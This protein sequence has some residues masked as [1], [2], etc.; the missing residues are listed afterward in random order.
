MGWFVGNCDSLDKFFNA[1][2]GWNP[3]NGEG[4]VRKAAFSNW[5]TNGV[6]RLCG[7]RN[8]S[9]EMLK[10]AGLDIA[11]ITV[12]DYSGQGSRT[13]EQASGVISEAQAKRLWAI[14][15][16][17]GWEQVHV[18]ILLESFEIAHTADILR[19]KYEGIIKVLEQAPPAEIV[20]EAKNRADGKKE[21][22]T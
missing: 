4:D 5:I 21:A 6:T 20:A 12:V 16:G 7:I 11:K 1:R 9:E 15:R 22:S 17:K 8:P 10:K 18:S 3:S 2:P 19:S 14:A 13:A